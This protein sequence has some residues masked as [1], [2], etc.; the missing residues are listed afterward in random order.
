MD[1]K[2]ALSLV[3]LALATGIGCAGSSAQACR[4][5]SEEELDAL[6]AGE[7]LCD[8]QVI[9]LGGLEQLTVEGA[10]MGA[11]GLDVYTNTNLQVLSAAESEMSYLI[12]K[13]NL[14]LSQVSL[15]DSVIAGVSVIDN[16]VLD[17]KVSELIVSG[18]FRVYSEPMTE[19]VIA[20][21]Q[22]QFLDLFDLDDLRSLDLASSNIEE[23]TIQNCPLLSVAGIERANFLHCGNFDDAPCGT[24]NL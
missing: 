2:L 24:P 21:S 16:S 15:S 1:L 12:V 10:Q 11:Y 23:L 7:A 17:L 5:E 6:L 20:D 4:A 18:S 13:E 19:L 14:A 22:I 9:D 8:I 3:C